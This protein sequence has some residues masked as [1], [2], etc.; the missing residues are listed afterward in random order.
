VHGD[1][2]P[3][4]ARGTTGAFT[5]LDWGDSGVGSPLLD[6]SAFLSRVPEDVRP[7]LLEHWALEWLAVVP[8]SDPRRASE[9]VRPIA[10]ARQAVIYQSFLDNI[11]PSEQVF[12]RGDPEAWLR[13]TLA[14]LTPRA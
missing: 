3:N 1:F 13:T 9:L 2:G 4:N 7:E 8:G 6:Q 14:E 12:H 5:I 10:A 11:E